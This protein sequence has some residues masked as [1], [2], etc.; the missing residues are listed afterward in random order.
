MYEFA[1]RFL[2]GEQNRKFANE[3]MMGPNTIRVAEEMAMQLSI[4]KSMRILYLGCG[5]GLSTLLLAK[6]YGVSVF[7]Q[8]LDIAHW[9]LQ[10]LQGD[11]HRR[12]GCAN[13]G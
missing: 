9:Q 1:N 10:T 2:S 11:G 5:C 3:N 4:N 6:K 12:Q 8:I 7:S 13:H